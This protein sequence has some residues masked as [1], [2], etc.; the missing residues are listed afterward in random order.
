MCGIAGWFEKRPERPEKDDAPLAAMLRQMAPRGP[1]DEG[2]VEIVPHAG[3][4]L[5]I[6][7]RRLAILDLSPAGHQPMLDA[8]TG[9]WL[10]YNG[11]I[12]NFR[13][14]RRELQALG[15]CFRSSCD[16]E[17]LLAG[18]RVWGEQVLARLRG[19]FAFALWDVAR[20]MLLLARDPLGVKPVYYTSSP[21][22]FLFASELRALLASGL[23]KRE[24]DATGL[25]SFLKFGAVQEPATLVRGVRLLPAGSLLRWSGDPPSVGIE[26][27]WNLPPAAEPMNGGGRDRKSRVEEMRAALSDAVRLRLES[28]VPLGV[29]L[30]GG[31]DSTAVASL[32]AQHGGT[33]KTFA[34]TFAEERFAEGEKARQ[35][36]RLLGTEHH[37]LTVSESDLLAALPQALAAMD[38]PTVDGINTYFVS[39]A[40]K[41]A[42]VT[43][44]LSGLGGDE[45]FA[46]YRSFRWVPRMERV[47]RWLPSWG[48]HIAGSLLDSRLFRGSRNQKLAL[49]MRREDGYPHPFYISRLLLPPAQV[50]RLLRPEWL[51]DIR[52]DEYAEE[53]A[54]Q[55][56]LLSSH[57]PV[58]RVSC[59]E[60]LVYLRNTLLRDADCMSMAHSLEVRVPLVDDVV[61]SVALRMPGAWKLDGWQRKP[62]LVAALPRPLPR[63]ILGQP[64]RGFEFPWPQWMRGQLRPALEEALA[65]PGAA[66]EPVFDWEQVRESW[67]EFLAGRR[68]WSRVWLFYVLQNWCERHLAA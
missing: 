40:T 22:R 49:W 56:R 60:V 20:Q 30:S 11:E 25:D 68:H 52:F 37:E 19:M 50:A 18:Y 1:D 51:L 9:N 66:L 33:I 32:A 54:T 27:Y 26:R 64:K 16:T 5:R 63:E 29:F 14:L 7:A 48:R 62:L 4:R 31:I 35:V 58:N 65:R 55:Q 12:F 10:V 41:K 15:C 47:E 45:L 23:V 28:D 6:G 61:T 24:L 38:Q 67:K 39:R 59:L 2:S 36:A 43:V 34:V 57:D 46:G 8:E 44:A 21:D 42:G 17:V 53:Y 13:E 3:G